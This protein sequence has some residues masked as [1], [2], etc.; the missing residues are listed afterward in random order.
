MCEDGRIEFITSLFGGLKN[1]TGFSLISVT[2][3]VNSGILSLPEERTLEGD[4][5]LPSPGVILHLLSPVQRLWPLPFPIGFAK[6][7]L[8]VLV[9]SI[10]P[11][12]SLQGS[13][14]CKIR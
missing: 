3:N 14:T 13:S 4:N 11:L 12:C 2:T 7:G 5:T 1:A 10:L 6:V 9:I 8:V